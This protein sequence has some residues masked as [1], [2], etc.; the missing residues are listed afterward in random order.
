[1]NLVSK[2]KHIETL[3]Q[4]WLD[5]Q[6]SGEAQISTSGVREWRVVRRPHAVQK[7]IKT[8]SDDMWQP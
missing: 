7:H 1:M 5:G 2:A 4:R 6:S 8:Y 3:L